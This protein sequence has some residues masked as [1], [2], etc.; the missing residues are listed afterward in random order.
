M[1]SKRYRLRDFLLLLMPA[2]WAVACGPTPELAEPVALEP[3]PRPAIDRLEEVARGRIDEARDR[4]DQQLASPAESPQLAGDFGELGRLYLAYDFRDAAAVCFANAAH[5]R[6]RDFRWCYFLAVTRQQQGDIETA[7]SKL[8]SC[9]ALRPRDVPAL[10]RLGGLELDLGHLR[11]AERLFSEAARLDPASAAAAHG[12]GRVA[13]LEQDPTS[14]IEHFERT[15]DLQPEAT[16]V[17]HALGL[18]YRRSGDLG[19]ARQLLANE[20]GSPVRFEDPLIDAL[21]QLVSGD[22]SIQLAAGSREA[23]QGNY[24]RAEAHF[25][26]ALELDPDDDRARSQLAAVLGR[27]GRHQEAIQELEMILEHNP[28]HR[29]AR[30]NLATALS[31]Q[32]Q[33]ELAIEGF[34]AVLELDPSDREARL[35]RALLASATGRFELAREDID[36]L[37]SDDRNDIEALL[38][39]AGLEQRGGSLEEAITIYRRAL[40]LDPGS[41]ASYL[42]IYGIR[43]KEQRYREARQE[44]EAGLSRVPDHPRMID[45][46]TRLLATCPDPAVRDGERALALA[47]ANHAAYPT[48]DHT[49]TLALALAEAGDFAGAQARQQE[50]LEAATERGAPSSVLTR[51]Q[52]HHELYRQNL[53]VRGG[54]PEGR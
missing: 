6:P 11:E 19:R 23:S 24:L 22:A 32:S 12:L 10:L 46:L 47:S 8:E 50:L 2:L 53:P 31:R 43:L 29:D 26:R 17:N 40:D 13:A 14:A 27:Q 49:E 34:T 25:Q 37:L 52:R 4:I 20:T 42:G 7:A 45:H 21:S 48:F 9:L 15:L 3:V 36:Q 51:L 16:A 33:G 1:H 5:L 39:L 30:F 38:A 28:A 54:P 35:R 41:P 44:L 18:A